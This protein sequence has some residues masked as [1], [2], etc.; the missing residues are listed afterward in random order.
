MLLRP[1][2]LAVALL[3]AA[4][5]AV[6]EPAAWFGYPPG[7]DGQLPTWER[8]AGWFQ[9]LAATSDRVRVEELGRTSGNR[10]LLAVFI[11]APQNLKDL[12][13]YREIQRRLADPRMTPP[14]EARHLVEQGR[15][16]VLITCSI[17][18][19]EPAST[20]SAIELSYRL[21]TAG[22]AE[23]RATLENTILILA[24]SLNPDGVD[25]V[26]E[27]YRRTLDTPW[28]GTSP[29]QLYNRYTGHDDNRDWYMF[30][31]LE[32]RLVVSRLHNEWHP[33]IVFDLHEHDRNG[34]RMFV[35]PWMDPIDPNLDSLLVA[36]GNAMGSA[37][38]ADLARAGKA[39]V[40]VH[41]LYDSWSPSRDYQGYHGGLRLLSESASAALA[42]PVT[43]TPEQIPGD[44]FGFN[45]RERSWNYPD[46]WLGGTWHLRDIVDYQLIAMESCL[47]QAAL[48]REELLRGFYEVGRRAVARM[49]PFAFV[50]GARQRDPGATRVLLDT[51]RFGGVEIS[52]AAA[53]FEAAGR[54]WEAGSWVIPMQQPYSA[55]AK[56][57]LERQRYPDV[58]Q[59]PGGPQSRPY[60]VA[61]WTLP[62]LMGVEAEA[63]ARPFHASLEPA[64]R[65][66]SSEPAAV[67]SAADTDSWMEVNRLWSAHRPVWRDR[68]TGDFS[69][70]KRRLAH[71]VPLPQPRIG[72]YQG[73]M[74]QVDEGW[75][76]W[77]FD[78]FGFA[79]KTVRTSEV[80]SSRLRDGFDAIVIPDQTPASLESGFGEDA[81]PKEYT[82][83]LGL[84]GAEA[85]RGFVHAG[86]TLVLLNRSAAWAIR[87]FG[88]KVENVTAGF[89]PREYSA[90]GSILNAVV[91]RASALAYG[92]PDNICVWSEAS[93]VWRVAE[94]GARTV[95]SYPASNV[96]ASGRLTGERHIAGRAALVDVPLGSGHVILFGF[97][98]QYRGQSYQTFKL[99]FNA[100]IGE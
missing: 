11:S 15:T 95:V 78:H 47:R 100:L 70:D 26:S 25:I 87:Q 30:T 64:A 61:A 18:S 84:K 81:M 1:A 44:A 38:A 7:A 69:A 86:G 50:I 82:G 75:T 32:T 80:L 96:L 76:R 92:V 33:Q 2:F 34:P 91:D 88:L 67:L 85:L 59:Y 56:T 53:A 72:L 77:L 79:W 74:P 4:R 60:D 17:H 23:T 3:I 27:W 65:A 54:T 20:E 24:P 49:D 22:D 68:R 42:T 48:Q 8:V 6:P 19:T 40:V 97:R 66:A 37:I 5:A 71:P 46:P 36:E 55:W 35:P 58:T 16:V 41:A 9:Q 98:P 99:F 21:A 62:L 94:A 93:P 14:A 63:I 52:Q 29:P 83:G 45:P 43:I 90:P 28:E 31:Q 12:D 73:W 10:P 13:R 39:G 51:L 57:L 89:A